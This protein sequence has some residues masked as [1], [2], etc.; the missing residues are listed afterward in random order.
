MDKKNICI[1]EKNGIVTLIINRP[2]ALNALDFDSVSELNEA[3]NSIKKQKKLKGLIITGK[4]EKAFC[5]GG[6]LS[7]MKFLTAENYYAFLESALEAFQKIW[8]LPFPSVAAINGYAF[9]GGLELSMVCDMRIAVSHARLALPEL[10][11]GLIPGW[12]GVHFMS[13][14]IG[15]AKTLQIVLQGEDI[16]AEKALEIGLINQITNLDDLLTEA[17][18]L[19]EKIHKKGP[20]AVKLVKQIIN[21]YQSTDIRK[22]CLHEALCSMASFATEDAQK[23]LEEAHKKFKK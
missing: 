13:R 5:A 6:D 23:R 17:K 9:G 7:K 20:F 14:L 19:I 16:S 18:A 22:A 2:D 21:D 4:G 8:E 1:E 10:E 3:V 11:Y 15:R 12:G